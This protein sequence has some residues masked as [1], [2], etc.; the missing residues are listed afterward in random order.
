MTVRQLIAELQQL[1]PNMTVRVFNGSDSNPE[2]AEATVATV[3][4]TDWDEETDQPTE[5]AVVIGY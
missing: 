1:P 4:E 5:T 3:V 2:Y